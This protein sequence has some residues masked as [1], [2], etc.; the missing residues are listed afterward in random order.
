[1]P[2]SCSHDDNTCFFCVFFLLI[3]TLGYMWGKDLDLAEGDRGGGG[4]E[5]ALESWGGGECDSRM[6]DSFRICCFFSSLLS[7]C[8]IER[9]GYPMRFR[10]VLFL[11]F[12]YCLLKTKKKTKK[13]RIR[14]LVWSEGGGSIPLNRIRKSRN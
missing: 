8:P 13:E 14:C 6:L 10:D 5:R 1:M 2:E 3:K 11:F 4:V 7:C 12:Y 9:A